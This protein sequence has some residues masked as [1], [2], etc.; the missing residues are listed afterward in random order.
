[1]SKYH[2]NYSYDPIGT[3]YDLQGKNPSKFYATTKTGG[4]RAWISISNLRSK[5]GKY[6]GGFWFYLVKVYFETTPV[7]G[8]VVMLNGDTRIYDGSF[9]CYTTLAVNYPPQWEWYPESYYHDNLVPYGASAWNAM[10]PDTPDFSLAQSM[11]EMKDIVPNL[12][13]AV[14]GHVK[15]IRNV[16]YK[17][18][19]RGK[20]E[21][22]RSGEWYLA[23][24]FGWLPVLNDVQNYAKA[25]NSAQGRVDNLIKNEGKPVKRARK[26]PP[27]VPPYS[28]YVAET[29]GTPWNSWMRPAF[30][31]QAY[32]SGK[33]THSAKG[34]VTNSTWCEGQYRWFLPPGPRTVDWHKRLLNRNTDTRLTPAVVYNLMPWSWLADYFTDLGDFVENCSAGMADLLITDFAF[35]MS[36]TEYKNVTVVTESIRTGPEG[37]SETATATATQVAVQKARYFAS[38][39]GFGFNKN[40]LTLKQGAIL[41]ALGISKLP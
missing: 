20:S 40:S 3:Q 5:D 15:K 9:I 10:R 32:G 21:L 7:R 25:H 24:N 4:R 38:P 39:F 26:L 8:P 22:S 30:V 28:G 36:T 1:M 23:I 29:H 6:R 2:Q 34:T 19:S 13:E 27:L 31:T 35:I 12:K 18:K 14:F 11:L 16:N 17:R 37:R 41:G 33:A